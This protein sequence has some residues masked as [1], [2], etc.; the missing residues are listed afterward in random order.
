MTGLFVR[1]LRDKLRPSN[2]SLMKDERSV[3]MK[4]ILTAL[5][6]A[7]F[8]VAGVA[9]P[10][11]ARADGCYICGSGSSDACKNYCRYSGS[12]TSDNRK[13]CQK[14]GCKVSGTA[15]CPTAVNYKVCWAPTRKDMIPA[16]WM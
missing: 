14:R 5:V 12:D 13:I 15:S 11:L 8:T 9:L 16:S 1:L 2:P 6:L 4:R 10:S 3:P 7:L